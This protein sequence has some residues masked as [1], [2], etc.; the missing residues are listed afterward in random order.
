LLFVKGLGLLILIA[1]IFFAPMFG[2]YYLVRFIFRSLNKNGPEKRADLKYSEQILSSKFV[3][4]QRLNDTDK[5][6]FLK[7][8]VNFIDTK[9][10]QGCGGIELT[11]EMIVLISASAIQLTFGLDEFLLDHFSKIF[12]YPNVYYSR[13]N[14]QY[15][16]GETNLAGAIVLSWNHFLEGYNKPHDKVNLGLHEMAHALRFDKFKNDDYDYFFNTYF[17]KWQAIAKDEFKRTKDG[18]SPFFREYGGT[19]ANE[20]FAVCVESFFESPAGF[21]KLHPEIYKHMCILLNQDPLANPFI[22]NENTPRISLNKVQPVS[23]NLLYTSSSNTKSILS[24]IFAIGFW[25]WFTITNLKDGFS[26]DIILFSLAMLIT[27]Y[28][29]VMRAFSK[30]HFYDNGIIVTSLIPDVLDKKN[31]FSYDEIVSIEFI[32]EHGDDVSDTIKLTYLSNGKIRT[33]SFSDNFISNAVLRIA[34]ILQSKK[35]A[36]KLKHS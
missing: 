27:G 35:I 19:N 16:K 1:A 26:L 29:I 5:T 32:N 13:I 12:V 36:V 11:Q 24:L 3:Y 22:P 30:I 31:E 7:R 4:Y 9:D 10:F 14:K 20:F 18:S 33:R 8:L 25:L 17:D 6:K 34:D 23:G 2:L 21:K 28:F 15:H